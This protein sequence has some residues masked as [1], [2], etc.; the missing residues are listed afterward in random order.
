MPIITVT[1]L[2]QPLRIQTRILPVELNT[3]NAGF[4]YVVHQALCNA[5]GLQKHPTLFLEGKNTSRVDQYGD[6]GLAFH[7]TRYVSAEGMIAILAHELAHV[8]QMGDTREN[9]PEG[10]LERQAI[11]RTITH[12]PLLR[13]TEYFLRKKPES[14][15]WQ[16]MNRLVESIAVWNLDHY[17]NAHGEMLFAAD[18]DADRRG[19]E[20]IGAAPFVRLF[21]KL[22]QEYV[23]N[24]HNPATFIPNH[25][26]EAATSPQMI[27]A[28]LQIAKA[29]L[30]KQQASCFIPPVDLPALL[31]HY[32]EQCTTNGKQVPVPT[33]ESTPVTQQLRK[34]YQEAGLQNRHHNEAAKYGT[35]EFAFEF[36][37]QHNQTFLDRS[38][39]D[40][41]ALRLYVRRVLQ[42]HDGN[43]SLTITKLRELEGNVAAQAVWN[44]FGNPEERQAFFVESA[45]HISPTGYL[46][47]GEYLSET[48][49]GLINEQRQ[50]LFTARRVTEASTRS[51]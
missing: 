35:A 48:L 19:M 23:K 27:W 25:G 50:H 43:H 26:D 12:H 34:L 6:V 21:E 1:A 40:I 32:A 49:R 24:G 14:T 3:G 11:V 41:L 18:I 33:I 4:L 7:E 38:V 46:T 10:F 22:L 20:W 15:F 31:A 5:G 17:D 29:I 45:E 28:R 9:L 2:D 30:E 47:T 39:E 37:I 51:I 8:Q 42:Q 13:L 36:F 16:H 44:S